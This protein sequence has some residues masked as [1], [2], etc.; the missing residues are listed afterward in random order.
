MAESRPGSMAESR[1]GSMAGGAGRPPLDLSVYLVTDTVQCGAL[2][3]AETVRRAVAAG[4][5]LVQLRDPDCPDEEFV[6]LGREVAAALAGSGVP[7]IVNDRVPLVAAIGADGAHVGQGDMPVRRA[8]ELLG[9]AGLLGLSVNNP[10][11]LARALADDPDRTVIDYLG[12]GIYRPTATKLDH[13]PATG[14]A[15]MAA[16]AAASPWPTCAIG[17]VKAAD[18]AALRGAGIDGMAVVS[19]ICGQTDIEGATA[20]LARAWAA[21]R[22]P[23]V[24]RGTPDVRRGTPDVRHPE[25]KEQP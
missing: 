20:E 12:L 14:L 6:R 21:A 15:P 18:A 17:G 13:A 8:R 10:D 22:P 9:D 16:L 4:V 23:D 19:A 7:L 25:R 24:R 11:D 5:T 1:P 3:V 2:G